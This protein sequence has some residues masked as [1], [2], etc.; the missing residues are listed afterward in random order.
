M[1][2]VG[3]EW[4]NDYMQPVF[5]A[6][7]NHIDGGNAVDQLANKLADLHHALSQK[8]LGTLEEPGVVTQIVLAGMGAANQSLLKNKPAN[9]D[10]AVKAITLNVDWNLISKEAYE[11]AQTYTYDL[12]KNL[13]AETVKKVQAALSAWAVSGGTTSDLRALLEPIFNDKARAQLVAETEGTRI[14]NEGAQK[15][16]ANVGVNKM[17]FLT[18][19][20]GLV[21][22]TCKNLYG[23]I[24]VVGQGWQVDGVTYYIPVH[25]RCRCFSRPVIDEGTFQ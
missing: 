7:V 19:R 1:E 18:V 14:F 11:F 10:K 5:E 3:S 6:V 13:D 22:P 4:V 24:G 15:R 17:K 25:P 20:D 12:I 9:P 2:K 23:A 16:W 8:W 21:C